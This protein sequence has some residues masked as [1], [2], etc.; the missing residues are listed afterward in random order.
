MTILIDARFDDYPGPDGSTS[1]R[2]GQGCAPIWLIQ[3]PG[4]G[5]NDMNGASYPNGAPVDPAAGISHVTL[6]PDPAGS[7]KTVCRMV[8]DPNQ[9]L[10]TGGYLRT[11]F[12]FPTGNNNDNSQATSEMAQPAS[13]DYWFWTSFYL[14]A[15]WNPGAPLVLL[16]LHDSAE[17]PTTLDPNFILTTVEYENSF[18]SGA[19]LSKL[20]FRKA[21]SSVDGENPATLANMVRSNCGGWDTIPTG[22]WVELVIRA[23]AGSSDAIGRT[24]IWIDRR[25]VFSEEKR[26]SYGGKLFG[27]QFHIGLYG[28]WGATQGSGWTLNRATLYTR[29]AVIGDKN[30]ADFNAFMTA[31][32]WPSKTE[33]EPAGPSVSI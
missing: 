2:V 7:G 21:N 23:R 18:K 33:L 1:G 9:T 26:N 16:Q 19:R 10:L 17:A 3:A 20:Y 31:L 5:G 28:Y 8:L 29:G 25:R 24:T 12:T 32:G 15:D 27:H 4:N 6:V 13:S 14:P 11:E 30:H 22:R